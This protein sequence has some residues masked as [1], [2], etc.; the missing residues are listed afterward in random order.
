M[1]GGPLGF[2]RLIRV[3]I[4]QQEGPDL[5]VLLLLQAELKM[6]RL[7]VVDWEGYEVGQIALNLQ[8][9]GIV[10]SKDDIF[11]SKDGFDAC[12]SLGQGSM[13]NSKRRRCS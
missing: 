11:L 9:D 7:L 13:C 12:H 6:V 2:M 5:L 1:P 10:L 4:L 3:G 8:K